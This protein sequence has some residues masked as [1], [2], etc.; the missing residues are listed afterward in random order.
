MKQASLNDEVMTVKE[1]AKFLRVKERT[2]FYWKARGKL[3]GGFKI[4]RSVRWL[5][6]EVIN[7]IK[8]SGDK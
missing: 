6:S 5:K 7:F 8:E 2:I 3:P 4:G 1:V